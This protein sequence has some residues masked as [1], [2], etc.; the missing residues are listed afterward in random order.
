M[1]LRS[2]W[3]RL[4]SSVAELDAQE[5]RVDAERAGAAAIEAMKALNVYDALQPKI[6]QGN[7]ITQAFQFVDT[8]NAELGFIAQSQIIDRKYN[9]G[10][11]VPQKLYSEIRQDAV[12]LKN[13][14][15]NEGAKAFLVFLKGTM[16]RDII[17]K[18]G[19]YIANRS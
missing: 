6:V 5:L 2:W 4:N 18:F 15:K 9:S 11:Q 19:Y 16:A 8:E 14:E 12:L 3:E 17:K 7:N 1:S 10:W 13:G